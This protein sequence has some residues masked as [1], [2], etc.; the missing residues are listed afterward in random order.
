MIDREFIYIYIYLNAVI[1]VTPRRKCLRVNSSLLRMFFTFALAF[2]FF[3]FFHS[4]SFR[5]SSPFLRSLTYELLQAP[6][7]LE[8]KQNK[9]KKTKKKKKK[10]L[11]QAERNQARAIFS[12]YRFFFFFFS[13]FFLILLANFINQLLFFNSIYVNDLLWIFIVLSF[14]IF[15]SRFHFNLIEHSSRGANCSIVKRGKK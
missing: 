11:H 7:R 14:K 2:L 6:Y 9:K 4:F 10:K 12:L 3:P 13:F 15:L 8:K 1:V 5:S